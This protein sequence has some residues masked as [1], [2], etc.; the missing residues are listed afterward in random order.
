MPLRLTRI[1]SN[2]YREPNDCERSELTP[3]TQSIYASLQDGKIR[4]ARAFVGRRTAQPPI[5][6]GPSIPHQSAGYLLVFLLVRDLARRLND[7]TW[8]PALPLVAIAAL[9]AT[10]GLF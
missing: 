4:R 8:I 9:E 10:L 6:G 7:S 1:V 2:L 5:T 3:E